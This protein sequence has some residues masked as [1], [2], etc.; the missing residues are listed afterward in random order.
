MRVVPSW[1]AFLV[2]SAVEASGASFYYLGLPPLGRGEGGDRGPIGDVR[3]RVAEHK[4]G[5]AN[6]TG[7]YLSRINTF[8]RQAV[9]SKLKHAYDDR[10]GPEAARFRGWR[11]PTF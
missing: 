10:L 4:W 2:R 11:R 1:S 8:W 5:D 6:R 7:L 3:Q 9:A